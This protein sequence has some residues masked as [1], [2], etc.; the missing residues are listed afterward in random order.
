MGMNKCHLEHILN[1]APKCISKIYTYFYCIENGKTFHLHTYNIIIN[2]LK[3]IKL[4]SLLHCPLPPA[5]W[6]A[7]FEGGLMHQTAIPFQVF[8]DV[9]V[10]FLLSR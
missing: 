10:C 3:S 2:V 6:V 4:N 1:F 8:D 9:L 5:E 7:M